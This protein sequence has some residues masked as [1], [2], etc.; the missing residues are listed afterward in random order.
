LSLIRTRSHV[1]ALDTEG[2]I[3]AE[4]R[5]N[6][7]G[8]ELFEKW[9]QEIWQRVRQVSGLLEKRH[10]TQLTRLGCH[11]SSDHVFVAVAKRTDQYLVTEDSDFG[12]GHLN[13]AIAKAG[14][15]AYM[16]EKLGLTVHDARE[17][18]NHLSGENP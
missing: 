2:K 14:V 10:M 15:T 12:K 13:R 11:E 8:I 9:Y 6:C 17:A 18:R 7:S 5:G 16:R 4:Y 1:I 3:L